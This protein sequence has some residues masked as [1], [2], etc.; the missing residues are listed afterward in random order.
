VVSNAPHFSPIVPLQQQQHSAETSPDKFTVVMPPGTVLLSDAYGLTGRDRV[1]T[2]SPDS[3]Q[4]PKLGDKLSVSRSVAS[5]RTT[6]SLADEID[7]NTT[8]SSSSSVEPMSNFETTRRKKTISFL[9]RIREM[10]KG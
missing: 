2:V 3:H 8:S 5:V 7:I 10:D 6:L 4:T 9:R 1:T